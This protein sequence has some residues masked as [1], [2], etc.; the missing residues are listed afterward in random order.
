M[1]LFTLRTFLEVLNQTS[2]NVS[3]AWFAIVLVSPGFL[4]MSSLQQYFELLI[5]NVP[6]GIVS[7][8]LNSWLA[9][10]NKTL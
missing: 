3:S 2:I 4:E 7:L 1:R 10:R 8:I 6:L 9:E 5:K